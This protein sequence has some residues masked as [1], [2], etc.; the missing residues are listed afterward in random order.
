MDIDALLY[1]GSVSIY[2]DK[3]KGIV[4]YTLFKNDDGYYVPTPL[5]DKLLKRV[6]LLKNIKNKLEAGNKI[7]MID[8]NAYLG[9]SNN[10]GSYCENDIFFADYTSKEFS[11]LA[12]LSSLDE[13][14]K[15]NNI[16][17]KK[18]IKIDGYYR[19]SR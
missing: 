5:S 9:K 7:Y 16:V 8:D 11:Y 10:E 4:G 1:Y 14:V 2:N 18:L 17:H 3:D 13:N 15:N 6:L 19:E 12:L